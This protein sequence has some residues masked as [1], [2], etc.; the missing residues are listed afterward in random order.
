MIRRARLGIGMAGVAAIALVALPAAAQ[1]GD[2]SPPRTVWGHPDL[3]GDWTNATLTPLERPAGQGPVLS[4]AEAARIEAEREA[5]YQAS[6]APSDPDRPAPPA[7]GDG[8]P[9]NSAGGGTGGYNSVYID[10][11]DQMALV[12]GEY[13]TSLIT[14]PADGQVPELTAAAR[15]EVAAYREWRNQFGSYD[16]PEN[17][18]LGERCILSF[19]SNAG[20]PMLPN[21]FYNNNYTI[22]QTENEILINIEMVHDTRIIR[23]GER[24]PLPDHVRPWF[25]DSWGRWEA[26]TLVVETTNIH[27]D[28]RFRGMSSDDLTVIERF[29]RADDE[30]ILYRFEIRDPTTYARPWGGEV[31]MLR[32]ATGEFLYEYACHEANYALYNILRGARAQEAAGGEAVPDPDDQ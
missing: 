32:M 29:H 20:P 22:V 27:P 31:P 13:R 9:I 1:S 15:R 12:N 18:P 2:Y 25:G 21:G 11:G 4:D 17:R 24:R 10:R 19:G 23:L 14:F 26:D 30:T 16:N 5:R 3:Q 8:S 6:L 7:G 28:Q